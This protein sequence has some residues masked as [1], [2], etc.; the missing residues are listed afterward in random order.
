MNMGQ[1]PG[2]TWHPPHSSSGR[3]PP[4]P[5]RDISWS[6][7]PEEERLNSW[8][9]PNHLCACDSMIAHTAEDWNVNKH[10]DNTVWTCTHTDLL[11]RGERLSIATA[12]EEA[13]ENMG[14]WTP[15]PALLTYLWSVSPHNNPAGC[16]LSMIL[17]INLWE[18]LCDEQDLSS[19]P[20]Y[21]KSKILNSTWL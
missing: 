21:S 5:Q 1:M 17:Y 19:N 14:L 12:S 2:E 15:S 7:T 13:D 10:K 8:D 4:S 18:T 3:S 9:P 16:N 11:R 6:Q 20:V